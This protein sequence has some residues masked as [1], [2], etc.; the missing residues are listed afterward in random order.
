MDAV[1]SLKLICLSG[2]CTNRLDLERAATLFSFVKKDRRFGGRLCVALSGATLWIYVSGK[3]TV[4]GREVGQVEAAYAV[5]RRRLKE[6]GHAADVSDPAPWNVVRQ[7]ETD[8]RERLSLRKISGRIP[9][10][11]FERA[12]RAVLCHLNHGIDEIAGHTLVQIYGSGKLLIRGRHKGALPKAVRDLIPT[13]ESAGQAVSG[14]AVHRPL[15][16]VG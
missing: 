9:G 1:T 14:G 16:H 5:A 7:I 6:S 4:L 8:P 13:V 3:M 12:Q 10:S 11:R 15:G 2:S